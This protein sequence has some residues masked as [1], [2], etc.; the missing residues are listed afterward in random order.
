MKNSQTNKIIY[1]LTVLN[2]YLTFLYFII[3]SFF[4]RKVW[5]TKTGEPWR[6]S[7]REPPKPRFESFSQK[8]EIFRINK[9]RSIDV[10]FIDNKVCLS[11]GNGMTCLS[12]FYRLSPD[13]TVKYWEIYNLSGVRG[14]YQN[15][16]DNEIKSRILNGEISIKEWDHNKPLWSWQNNFDELVVKN[17]TNIINQCDN[18]NY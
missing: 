17:K 14:G 2:C 12:S 8:C 16:T 10:M 7:I 3:Q 4:V 5:I 11:N 13:G 9:D 15:I 18:I 1:S 6:F